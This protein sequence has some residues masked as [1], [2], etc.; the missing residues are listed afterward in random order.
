MNQSTTAAILC[1]A[2]LFGLL[3]TAGLGFPT[4]EVSWQKTE[5]LAL[6]VGALGIVAAVVVPRFWRTGPRLKWWLVASLIATL[7][8]FYFQVRVPQPESNDVSRSVFE[9]SE[10][11]DAQSVKI[12]GKVIAMPAVTRSG[13][14]Q[15][16][17]VAHQLNDTEIVTGKLYV[18]VPLLQATGV[19]PGQR[20]T[21]VGKLYK[22]KTASNPGAFDFQAYLAREG[23]FAGLSGQQLILSNETHQPLWGWW[24]LRRRI[25]R[26]QVR[27][28]YSP[29]GQ[30]VS[31]IVLG[32]KAVDLPYEIRDR[33]IQAG[34]AHVLAASGFHVSLLLGVV[35]ALTRRLS[36]QTQFLIGLTTLV[37]YIGLT[38]IQPS[39][40]R[41]AI[42]GVGALFALVSERKVKPLGSLLLAATLL[43]LYNPLWI[44]DLGFQLSFLATLG[45]L[46]TLPWVVKRLDWLPPAIAT[47]IAIPLAVFPWVLPLQLYVF[48]VVAP[49]SILV[50]ILTVPLIVVISIGGMIS[51]LAALVVPVLGSAIALLLYYPTHWLIAIVN[52]FTELPGNSLA[53]GTISWVQ[54]VALYGLIGLIWLSQWWQSRW[55]FASIFAVV[56]IVFP[57]WQSQTSL[58]Q[59]TVLAS[60]QEQILV[61]QDQGKVT[62]VNSGDAD[63]AMFTV[64]PFLRQQGINRVDLAVAFDPQP[65]LQSGWD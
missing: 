21:V 39:V 1:L 65:H 23:A 58:L 50:N 24:K 19:Y 63:T 30:L 8:V 60:N 18:T 26:A 55:G 57:F 28:L 31:S 16:W 53:L 14:S 32:R 4:N 20:V 13:R 40:M 2:Y 22:P 59:V 62:L 36:K 42:M 56:L 11:L 38:G 45:L 52:F 37:I 64:L 51:A 15:L 29:A 43:L 6:G 47:I 41:A 35:L 10:S 61:I 54:L 5:I 33:F 12:D 44:W 17:L 27:W 49:Y 34:L 48:G 25:I 9:V 3:S 46:V 7:A